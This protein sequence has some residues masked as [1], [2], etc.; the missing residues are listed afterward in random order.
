MNKKDKDQFIKLS[1]ALADVAK[2]HTLKYFRL[3]SVSIHSK[4]ELTFDPVTIADRQAEKAMRELIELERPE[5]G[6]LGE[7]Y[8][9]KTGSTGYTW[10]LDPI[11]GTRGY[12]SGTPT[13]GT[14]IALNHNGLPIYGVIDQPYIGERFSGG[15]DEAIFRGPLDNKNLSVSNV[16]EFRDA[17]LFSTYPEIGTSEELRGFKQ[18]AEKCKLTRYGLDCY[19]YGLL[20]MGNIDIVIEAGL[21]P[22]DVQA[23][24]AVIKAAGGN[25]TNWNGG[26]A[27]LGGRVLATGSLELHEKALNILKL[28]S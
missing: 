18:V 3:D 17:V 5:D 4:E 28:I 24:I 6:I 9:S 7:E 20:A 16:E 10:V 27:E 23:P 8:P 14:L 2:A 13:W 21:K 22:Y 1:H 19:A 12:I 11:D 26:P 15:L 25:V